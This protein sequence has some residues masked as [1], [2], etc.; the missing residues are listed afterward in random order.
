[1]TASAGPDRD[2]SSSTKP[3][4]PEGALATLLT[5]SATLPVSD[6]TRAV[7]LAGEALGATSARML[8]AD[9]GLT[10]MQEL[11][12]AGPTGPRRPIDGT[13]AGR[14]FASGQV[15]TAAGGG[16][17]VWVPLCEGSERLGVLELEHP[18]WSDDSAVRAAAIIRVLVLV[19]ISKRR[20][21]DVVLRGRRA[22]PL[23]IAAEIQWALLPPLTC[24]AT[25]VSVSGILEPAYSIGG[26]CFDYALNPDRAEFAIVDAVGHGIAAVSIAV[27]AL[28]ALRNA[29][30]EGHGLEQAYLDAGAVL[31]AEIGGAAFATAQIG[32]LEYQTGELTWVNAGHPLPLLI[33]DRS[34]IGELACVPSRPI[35]LGG[36][37]QEVAVEPLQPGDRVLF[38]TDGVTESRAPD[39]DLFGVDRLADLAVRASTE[40]TSPAETV[41]R[42]AASV[43][44]YN[45]HSLRDDA[46]LFMLEYHGTP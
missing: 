8:V 17:N 9:Y 25:T 11:G 28:N 3:S 2:A 43:L 42:L 26:D 19:L 20:Y 41:R 34:F 46:T 40:R 32:S 21:T 36:P 1:M 6:V 23:S 44:E 39:G 31:R 4:D 5:E 14:S 10:T 7:E 22:E 15:V 35:G 38:Y 33:R 18:A 45:G 29:R 12:L 30:R 27:L 37:V 24:S 16:R 13:L